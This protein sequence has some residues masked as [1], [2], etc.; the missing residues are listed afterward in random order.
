[1]PFGQEEG[2]ND[3]CNLIGTTNEVLPGEAHHAETRCHEPVLA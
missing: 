3:L 1:M 2:S